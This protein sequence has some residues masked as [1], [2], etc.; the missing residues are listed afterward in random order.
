MMGLGLL[1]LLLRFRGALYSTRLLHM[2]AIAMGPAG[3]IAVL[4]GWI[5]TETGRQP[6]TVYGLLRTVDSASPLAAPAVASSLIAFII[7]YFA[8]FTMGVIY[9]LRLMAQPPHHGE[10]GPRSHV[11]ARA[12][13]I[14]PAAGAAAEGGAR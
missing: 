3:F 13:G 14:T 4:A 11:P 12:A 5:T 7:V 1:S 9:I 2:F 10:Q 6:F 8:V